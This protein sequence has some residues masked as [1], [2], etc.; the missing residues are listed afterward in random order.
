MYKIKEHIVCHG[1]DPHD[2]KPEWWLDVSLP[3]GMSLFY[4][5]FEGDIFRALEGKSVYAA[6]MWCSAFNGG[7]RWWTRS[8]SLAE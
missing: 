4:P 7:G 2:G 1:E 8:R 5:E 6:W 3:E